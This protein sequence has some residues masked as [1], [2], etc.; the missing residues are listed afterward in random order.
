MTV[1][2]KHFNRVFKAIMTIIKQPW[3]G[4]VLVA[5][6]TLTFQYCSQERD[7]KSDADRSLIWD[8]AKG[9]HRATGATTV[10]TSVYRP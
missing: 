10:P 7:K 5:A 3:A 9:I 4:T 6:M 2:H 8:Y 1:R